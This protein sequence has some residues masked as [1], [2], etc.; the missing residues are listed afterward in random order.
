MK[1]IMTK[2]VTTGGGQVG[3]FHCQCANSNNDN[4]FVTPVTTKFVLI[5]AW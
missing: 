4:A 5:P 1:A 2:S 3:V